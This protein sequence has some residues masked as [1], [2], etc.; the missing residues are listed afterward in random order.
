M[1]DPI[2]MKNN[3]E[4]NVVLTQIEYKIMV[5]AELIDKFI[6]EMLEMDTRDVTFEYQN[7]LL[8][9]TAATEIMDGAVLLL[10]QLQEHN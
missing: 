7:K 1:N 6:V 10:A 2:E 3:E 8:M 9:L 4:G 5:S